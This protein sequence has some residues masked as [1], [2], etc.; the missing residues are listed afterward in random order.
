[1]KVVI[2]GDI[3]L[4]LDQVSFPLGRTTNREQGSGKAYRDAMS[5]R[6]GADFFSA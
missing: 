2:V 1:M 5:E 6:G 3:K 4:R